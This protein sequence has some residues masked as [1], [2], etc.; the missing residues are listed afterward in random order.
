MPPRHRLARSACVSLSILL[1]TVT[2]ACDSRRPARTVALGA[3]QFTSEAQPI[4]ADIELCLPARLRKRQWNVEEHPYRVD[5]GMRAASN[6]EALARAVFRDVVVDFDE[7]CGDKTDRP[8]LT[9]EIVSANRDWDGIAGVLD[10]EPVDTALTMEFALYSDDGE[11][12]WSTRTKQR[13]RSS[14]Q[15]I[16]RRSTAG[17]TDFG[18]VLEKAL[19]EGYARILAS[20]E[21]R[22]AIEWRMPAADEDETTTTP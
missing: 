21:I 6:F 16:G 17:T 10:P 1:G 22:N 20:E 5:L 13:H 14:G 11:E 19:N 3:M 12:I 7:P 2:L 4:A 9:A 18:I 15:V 8:W